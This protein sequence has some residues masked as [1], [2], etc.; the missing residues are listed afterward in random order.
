MNSIINS[1]NGVNNDLKKKNSEIGATRRTRQKLLVR[2]VKLVKSLHGLVFE[3][4]FSF[5]FPVC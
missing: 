4:F 3:N 5:L 2:I 1:E